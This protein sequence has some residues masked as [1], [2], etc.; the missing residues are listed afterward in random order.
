MHQFV[1]IVEKWSEEKKGINKTQ[2]FSLVGIALFFGS[3]GSVGAGCKKKRGGASVRAD[4]IWQYIKA[5]ERNHW[6]GGR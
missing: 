4:R 2:K 5:E 3:G 6:D 1:C